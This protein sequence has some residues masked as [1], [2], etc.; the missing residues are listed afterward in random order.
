MDDDDRLFASA[1]GRKD[2]ASLLQTESLEPYSLDE[3]GTRIALLEAE[4]TR[5]KA[6]RAAA[7]AHR[8][9]AEALFQPRPDGSGTA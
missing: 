2:A 1:S 5:V 7:S 9:A 8:F 6:H 4:I 3:L